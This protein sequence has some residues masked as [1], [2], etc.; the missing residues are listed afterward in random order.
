MTQDQMDQ[1]LEALCFYSEEGL[2]GGEEPDY[3]A[4]Y[5]LLWDAW[6][7]LQTEVQVSS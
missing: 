3:A 1:I 6:R 2:C 7:A 4:E 5:E